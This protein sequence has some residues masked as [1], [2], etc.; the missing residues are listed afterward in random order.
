MTQKLIAA[1]TNLLVVTIVSTLPAVADQVA[2][3]SSYFHTSSTII[4][5]GGAIGPV[6]LI[7]NPIGPGNTDTVIERQADAIINGPAIPIELRALSL[8]SI[9]PVN[10]GG[11]FF[12]VLV[13]LDPAN[14]DKNTGTMSATGTLTQGTFDA[15]LNAF[16]IGQF[17]S[18]GS[19]DMSVQ[20]SI[21]LNFTKV[22]YKNV[23]LT[24][25]TVRVVGFDCD[26]SSCSIAQMLADR[27][28]NVHTGLSSDEIDLFTPLDATVPLP[29]TLPLFLTGL[30]AL[31][32][33]GWPRKKNA[34]GS[35]VAKHLSVGC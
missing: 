31:G 26:A 22:E 12:D 15:F 24:D 28:A 16:I 10:I 25:D 35:A 5:F 33:L 19:Q 7:G 13:T 3:G 20:E 32:L 9:A 14:I 11:V 21:S 30:G 4:D 34:G 6:S 17:H 27:A 2:L 8:M 29:G 1:I 18:A 23:A